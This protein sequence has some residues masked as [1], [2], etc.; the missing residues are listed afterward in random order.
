MSAKA[1]QTKS[2]TMYLTDCLS[3]SS[4]I[5]VNAGNKSIPNLSDTIVR[6]VTTVTIVVKLLSLISPLYLLSFMSLLSIL[7]LSSLLLLLPLV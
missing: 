5:Y 4:V 1:I 6:T 7:S 3:P 2:N